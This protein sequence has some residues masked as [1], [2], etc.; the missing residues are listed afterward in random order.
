[1]QRLANRDASLGI[2][3]SFESASRTAAERWRV[4]GIVSSVARRPGRRAA[5]R[6]VDEISPIMRVAEAW[7]FV[8]GP[9]NMRRLHHIPPAAQWTFA[10]VQR[11]D[12]LVAHTCDG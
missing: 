7:R 4:L 10:R 2:E 12:R 9:A 6:R 5:P 11:G 1:M 8:F 3:F